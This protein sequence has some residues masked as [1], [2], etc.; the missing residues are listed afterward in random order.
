MI[1]QAQGEPVED[2]EQL[3][4]LKN[5][6]QAGQALALQVCRQGEYLEITVTLV[7]SWQLEE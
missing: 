2:M 3:Q 7:E 5:S 4:A 6:M 1:V